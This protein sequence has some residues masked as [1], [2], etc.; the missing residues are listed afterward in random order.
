VARDA[1][2]HHGRRGQEREIGCRQGGKRRADRADGER[3][4]ED[5]SVAVTI[6]DVAERQLPRGDDGIDDA[7]SQ[8]ECGKRRAELVAE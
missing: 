2:A 7:D 4:N 8:T 3:A 6:G 5:G 1:G